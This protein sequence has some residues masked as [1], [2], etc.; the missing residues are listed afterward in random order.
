MFVLDTNVISELRHGKLNQSAQV[1]AW[2][3]GQSSSRLFLSAISILELEIGIRAL[4][5]RT[6]PQGSALR[7]WL[8]GV[9][10]AFAGR[11]LPFTEN[12]APVC[13]S[14]HVPNPCSERDAMIAATAI[15]H[16]FSVVTRN[17]PDFVN[18]GVGL[19]N[20]WDS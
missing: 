6:P 3:A 18:T 1:R 8:A 17:V 16:G 20:P 14:L 5:R 13:A 19:I 2:A 4:E 11:I 12:T 9:R 15:E 7:A 10:V